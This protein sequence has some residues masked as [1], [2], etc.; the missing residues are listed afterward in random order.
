MASRAQCSA[1]LP[2]VSSSGASSLRGPSTWRRSVSRTAPHA[3]WPSPRPDARPTTTPMRRCSPCRMCSTRL[4]RAQRRSPGP[5]P[6]CIRM[7][8]PWRTLPAASPRTRPARSPATRSSW[9]V[10]RTTGRRVGTGKRGNWALQDGPSRTG[11]RTCRTPP[12]S[13]GWFPCGEPTGALMERWPPA[14]VSTSCRRWS[15]KSIWGRAAS[16]S[17]SVRRGCSSRTRGET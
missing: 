8:R 7:R 2:L 11:I 4:R 1:A 3:P 13:R 17:C 14:C 6:N 5:C 10:P 15:G 12:S 16:P 9:R